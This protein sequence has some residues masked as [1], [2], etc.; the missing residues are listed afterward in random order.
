MSFSTVAVLACGLAVGISF[1]QTSAQIT[2]RITDPSALV[3][4][5]A[6]VTITDVDRGQT[7]RETS[8]D[9]GYYTA[10][11]LDVG[12]YS[13]TVK[14]EGF[15]SVTR[16]GVK[17]DVNESARID[18]VLEVGALTE[19]ISV[20]GESPLV[21]NS[22][23]E[24]G[25]VMSTEKIA[26]L[27][28]NGRNFS[29]LVLLTPGVS[30]ITVTQGAQTQ[31]VGIIAQPDING[32]SSRS[33]SFTLDGVYNNSAYINT[34]SVAPSIDALEE[35][36]VQS[37][38]DQAEFG[39]VSG[40]VIN[41]A[42]KSGTN[43][44]HGSAYEYIRNNALDAR[45][46][47]AAA[48]PALKQNQFGSALGGRIIKNKTFFFFSYEGYRQISEADTLAIVPTP[49]ELSGNFSATRSSLFDPF[50]TVVNPNGTYSRT[51]FPNNQIP[52]SQLDPSIRAW[53]NAILP[54]PILTGTP[55]YNAENVNSGKA[56]A[57]NYSLRLD[58]YL[59]AKDFVW[60]RYT[61][62]TQNPVAPGTFVGTRTLQTIPARNL[63]ASYSHTF[64]SN[65]VVTALFGFDSATSKS[66]S[67][68]T[69]T[70]LYPQYFPTFPANPPANPNATAP[71]ISASPFF[72]TSGDAAQN[73]PQQGWQG[74]SDLSHNFGRHS[75][76]F[77]AEFVRQSWV[78]KELNADISFNNAQTADLNNLG[79][80][81]SAMASLMMG[82]FQSAELANSDYAL[83]DDL[84]DVYVQDNWKASSKLTVNY[85][86]R[87]DLQLVP[88][89][90]K[91]FPS[92]W[93]F[94]T[95]QYL[96]GTTKPPQCT[97]QQLAQVSNVLSPPCLV[98]PND[99]YL[100]AHVVF[101][102]NSQIRTNNYKMFGP[103]IGLAYQLTPKTVIRTSYGIFY[104]L[105]GYVTQQAQNGAVDS[106]NWPG[107]RGELIYPNTTFVTATARD[108]FGNMNPLINPATPAAVT[109]HYYDPNFQDPYS[110]QW[111]FEVQRELSK[112]HI[113]SVAYVGSHNVR[114]A[115][116]AEYNTALTPGPGDPSIRRPFPWAPST[117]Y[118]RSI[119]Q[120]NYQSL[121]AKAERRLTNGLAFLLAYTWSKSI[122]L[123]ASVQDSGGLSIEDPNNLHNSKS[124][125]AFDIP[126]L[127]T[128][129]TLYHLPVGPG[130][131]WLQQGIA[132]RILGNWQINAIVTLRSG[133]VFT[134]TTGV[135]IAN[136]GAVTSSSYDRPNLLF[137]PVLSNP[138]P[139]EWFNTKAFAAPAQYTYGSAG[140]DIIRDDNVRSFDLSLF[141]QQRVTERVRMEF[142]AESFNVLNHPS[143]GAPGLTFGSKTFG[144]VT[145]TSSTARQNQLSLR[146]VF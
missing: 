74:R 33:N 146:L 57:N 111:N 45:G 83:Q 14:K 133:Q 120:S 86:M 127:F 110:E 100:A 106:S 141:R 90:T 134:P 11:R 62:G 103:R 66:T 76:K 94:N 43:Q 109:G 93:D 118:D 121:Q 125:S 24:V 16:S 67:T 82:V 37:H 27:P 115:V 137:N 91:D 12:T 123:G 35:F 18:F 28:L 15:R 65:T 22:V 70:N 108:P 58:H 26:D 79:G 10:P 113:V 56:P 30:P 29:Q 78:T 68:L 89:Y 71:S 130:K 38:S 122:D 42:S 87:W 3:I 132:S 23:V 6:D 140:R 32:Q 138:T 73:G 25:T 97:A 21:E 101:T 39:G 102:G 85:G 142:R 40:G 4:V 119:G 95:G 44:F 17:L 128:A 77:V 2:G 69:N 5:G 126:Q 55:G 54:Q 81:G 112:N 50:S 48:N 59:S 139:Y 49:Q 1:A 19:E 47:F 80:T 136:I 92:D 84:F 52:A 99:P 41:I 7:K 53:I 36:K 143:F 144:Q 72:S 46:F 117:R 20:T 9:L 129:A 75:L 107:E 64:G 51:P 34:Y 96:V 8:N 135:D 98:N 145:S 13:I 114:L 116:P 105:M 124:V 61:W 88:K 63:G 104:D 60:F 131:R 31:K